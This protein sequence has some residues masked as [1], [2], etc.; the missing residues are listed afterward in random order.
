MSNLFKE[1]VYD[2]VVEV[3]NANTQEVVFKGGY[4]IGLYQN[5]IPYVVD[6]SSSNK[7]EYERVEVIPVSEEISNETPS[8]N[9][10]DR[11]DYYMQYQ[12]FFR[13]TRETEVKMALKEFRDYFFTNKQAELDGYTVA[14]KTS[15]GDKQ[16]TLPV[17]SGNFYSFYKIN[18]YLTAIKNGYIKKD[19]D[20][21]KMRLREIE[22]GAFNIGSSY[23]IS[24]VGDTDFTAL[25]ASSNTLGEIFIATGNGT[26]ISTGKAIMTS[27]AITEP[28]TYQI[29][30]LEDEL[31]GTGGDP[32]YS[33][34]TGISK[35]TISNKVAVPKM[36]VFYNSTEIDK[37]LYSVTMNKENKDALWDI[38]HIFDG[39]TFSYIALIKGGARTL[40]DNGIVL[41][42]LDW[43]EADV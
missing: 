23:Q 9:L 1:L 30:K 25:G 36:S 14:F 19:T 42:E 18:I 15:R 29:M 33:N 6:S 41:L 38:V 26:A 16:A 27:T 10:A 20:L 32:A 39:V 21:W 22:A 3:L 5:G 7:F 12:V 28:T 24:F 13:T 31:F 35:A 43:V 11:S 37:K 2:K 40:T 8:V 17:Q 34:K 4:L